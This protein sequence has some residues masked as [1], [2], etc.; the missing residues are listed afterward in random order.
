[1]DGMFM[2]AIWATIQNIC[3]SRLMG[4]FLDAHSQLVETGITGNIRGD[5]DPKMILMDQ[6][7][8]DRYAAIPYYFVR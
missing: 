7:E 3:I 1:M 4:N 5:Q 2:Y 8:G 6:Q